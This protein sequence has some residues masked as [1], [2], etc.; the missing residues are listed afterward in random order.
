V[1]HDELWI[2]GGTVVTA[3]GVMEADVWI[4]QG[5]IRRVAKDTLEKR[6]SEEAGRRLEVI[7]ATGMYLLPGFLA[8]PDFPLVRLHQVHDYLDAIRKLVRYG[9]TF[10]LDTLYLE[11]WMDE[12]Q[13]LY[14]QTPHFNNLIDYSV[15]IG[16]EADAF[17]SE[18]VRSLCR[19]GFRLFQI[20]LWKAGQLEQINWEEL[21]PL[22]SRYRLSAQLH[23]PA[24][25]RFTAE[26]RHEAERLWLRT[27]RRNKLRTCVS[28]IDPVEHAQVEPY[29]HLVRVAG[30]KC[31]RAMEYLAKQWYCSLPVLATLTDVVADTRKNL[32][33]PELLLCLLVRIASTNVAKAI[34]LYPQKGNL[35]PG[36]DADIVFVKKDD[37]L[38]K[39]SLSTI[40]KF[41]ENIL[42]TS[43]M[44][45]GRLI[46]REECF[47]PTIG[48]GRCLLDVKPYNYV[49]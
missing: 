27:S 14:H 16:I 34:G 43:V 7:D 19:E 24:N 37:W 8:L 12:A 36:A 29:Y 9:Y 30:D 38:T 41:S 4:E 10:V 15:Q 18:R 32:W 1:Q 31:G 44:S 17:R 39:F 40:L 25:A 49:I 47:A 3:Y 26:E 2:R 11:E 23:I 20:V 42:P 21:H 35:F 5:K 6:R 28:S 13:V 48:M 22:V 46:Y 33:D 45:K